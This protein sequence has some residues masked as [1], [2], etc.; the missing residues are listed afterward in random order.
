[1]NEKHI[2]CGEKW[3]V[4]IRNKK[5][6]GYDDNGKEIYQVVNEKEGGYNYNFALSKWLFIHSQAPNYYVG[7]SKKKIIGF[8][9]MDNNSNDSNDDNIKVSYNTDD[10][11]IEINTKKDDNQKSDTIIIKNIPHQKWINLVINYNSGILDIF[12]D[13]KL[14]GT[15]RAKTLNLSRT[16][17]LSVGEKHGVRGGLCNFVYFADSLTKQQ[18]VNN[19]EMYKNKSPPNI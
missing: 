14:V 11:T 1:M 7:N 9:H 12:L 4:T 18:I 8:R 3:K 16:A 5:F 13:G 15:G 19:Y 17:G 2:K 10:G 6:V